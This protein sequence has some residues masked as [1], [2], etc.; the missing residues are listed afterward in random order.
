[1]SSQ[2]NR[3]GLGLCPYRM[4]CSKRLKTLA[5]ARVILGIFSDGYYGN[6]MQR[7]NLSIF[8]INVYDAVRLD[9]LLLIAPPAWLRPFGNSQR[10]PSHHPT[11][12]LPRLQRYRNTDLVCR[13]VRGTRSWQVLLKRRD[14]GG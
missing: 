5:I 12:S 2:R 8:H 13:S 10:A 4:H 1:M 9:S 14:E 6:I 11:T 7:M 3:R